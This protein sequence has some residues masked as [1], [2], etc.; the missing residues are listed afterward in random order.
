MITSKQ[1]TILEFTIK[2]VRELFATRHDQVHGFEHAELVAGHAAYIATKEREDVLLS[3]L[4]GW[5]HDIGRA[6][7]DHPENFPQYDAT[8]THHELSYEMLRD[9][10]REDEGFGGLADEQKIELLYAVRY[11]WNDEANE[12][13]S[14]YILRD[15]DKIDGLGERGLQRSRDHYPQDE[16][17]YHMDIRLKFEQIFYIKTKTAKKMVKNMKLIA[18]INETRRALLIEAIQPIEL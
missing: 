1:Q 7:E 10:F 13:P 15:A 9:W 17:K 5:F 18:P 8:K 16:E 12:Y 6:I 11:H 2:R 4:A 3:T 14:A